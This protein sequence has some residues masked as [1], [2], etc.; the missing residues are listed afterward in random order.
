MRNKP[1][2]RLVWRLLNLVGR[3]ESYGQKCA[4]NR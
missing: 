1:I 3:F 2:Y 4:E